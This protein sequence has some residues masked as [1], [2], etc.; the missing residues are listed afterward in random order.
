MQIQ[1]TI[2]LM[3]KKEN[4]LRRKCRY[5]LKDVRFSLAQVTL[6]IEKLTTNRVVKD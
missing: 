2:L 4:R 1:E 6:T 5:L 3:Q